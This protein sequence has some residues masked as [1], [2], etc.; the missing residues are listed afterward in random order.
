MSYEV[1]SIHKTPFVHPDA[2]SIVLN[3]RKNLE[4]M[5]GLSKK[6]LP[7]IKFKADGAIV[8]AKIPWLP[9]SDEPLPTEL[10]LWKLYGWK[11]YSRRIFDA[12]VFFAL[13]NFFES[14]NQKFEEE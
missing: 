3:R 6:I 7:P 14:R 8:R 9:P 4:E 5:F 10:F 13:K 2:P 1:N 11:D 12:Q